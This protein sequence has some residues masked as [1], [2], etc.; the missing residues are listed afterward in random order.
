M[1]HVQ[2]SVIKPLMTPPIKSLEAIKSNLTEDR[3]EIGCL[4][5]GAKVYAAKDKRFVKFWVSGYARDYS[6]VK[7]VVDVSKLTCFCGKT[8]MP[9]AAYGSWCCPDALANARASR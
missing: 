3:S 8:H 2:W 5:T 7:D 4:K 6:D 1:F 9:V